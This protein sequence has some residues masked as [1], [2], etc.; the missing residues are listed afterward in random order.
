MW[1]LI[2][3]VL[4]VALYQLN[5]EQ[6]NLEVTD[7]VELEVTDIVELEATDIVELEVNNIVE[8]EEDCC[9]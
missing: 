2:W 7:I 8:V 3:P 9:L 1:P 5:I 4:P 6:H